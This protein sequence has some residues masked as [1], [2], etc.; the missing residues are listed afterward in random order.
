MKTLGEVA[1]Q[2]HHLTSVLDADGCPT[3]S[4][5]PRGRASGRKSWL[6][7]LREEHRLRTMILFLDIIHG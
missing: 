6:V 4:R 3:L 7:T 5:A 2:P 1:I